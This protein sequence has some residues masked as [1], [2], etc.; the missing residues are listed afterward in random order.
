MFD[1]IRKE[2]E[3]KEIYLGLLEKFEDLE[4]ATQEILAE[5]ER[6]SKTAASRRY[7]DLDY[8]TKLKMLEIFSRPEKRQLDLGSR[9]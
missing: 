3:A 1:K 5:I 7:G 4:P 2:Q 9:S 6:R 8:S